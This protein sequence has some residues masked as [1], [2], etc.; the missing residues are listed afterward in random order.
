MK[1]KVMNIL[2][3]PFSKKSMGDFIQEVLNGY[4]GEFV[5]FQASVAF[6][7]RSGVQHIKD[8]LKAFLERGTQARIVVG[9][10]LQG[11]S[12]E[13]LEALL[14]AMGDSGELLVNHDENTFVTF[15]PKVYFFEGTEKDLLIV[16]SGNLTQGGLYSNDE[17]FAILELDPSSPEDQAV[18]D[19]YKNAF[20][21]WCDDNSETVRR[22]D[23]NFI[24]ALKEAGYTPS[25][26]LVPA[27]SD[28]AEENAEEEAKESEGKSPLFGK[29][30]GR[31]RPP[32]R[33]VKP[34]KKPAVPLFGVPELSNGFVMTLMRTDVGTG[35]TTPGTSRRSP[36]IFIPLSARDAD[37]DFWGWDNEFTEDPSRP[38]KFDRQGVRMRIGGDVVSVNMM[39]W[40]A[41]HDFRLRSES[42]R[43][44]G[45]IG[46]LIK[47]EKVEGSKSFDYYVEIIP[48]GTSDYDSYFAI[49][50]N[51]TRNSERLWGYY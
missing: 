20:D 51:K 39:T 46:D 32:R 18:I 1:G 24:E 28:E 23:R 31:R 48:Q 44:A 13:G 49:C 25:E 40:P 15:H 26:I 30:K 37:P 6:A 5:S 22:V 41:K 34:K 36:E 50:T 10:D 19:Q 9:V 11:T 38:G 17:C 35:Q 33:K 8:Q 29:M 2:I 42:L 4:Y 43:S 21:R 12:S 27:E 7:K 14:D 16:G 47:I 3:Q 45:D